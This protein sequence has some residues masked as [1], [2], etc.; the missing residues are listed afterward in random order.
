MLLGN[1]GSI[2][3]G[4]ETFVCTFEEGESCLLISDYTSSKEMWEIDN[5]HGVVQDNTL[6]SGLYT[7][8]VHRFIT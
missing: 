5:G 3:T 7:H 8:A 4:R 6:S 2:V 1:H